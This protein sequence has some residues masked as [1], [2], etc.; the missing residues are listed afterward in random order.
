MNPKLQ[1]GQVVQLNPETTRN[2][3]FAGCLMVVSEPKAF[4]CQGY[5]QSL[6]EKGEP[7][8]QA[9]YRAQ[10]DEICIL[11]GDKAPWLIGTTADAAAANA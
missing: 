6:G 10:W 5:V 9:Y 7:G 2:Q 8:S 4:G 11:D 1:I 3:M